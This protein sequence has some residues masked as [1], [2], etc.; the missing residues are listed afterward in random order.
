MLWNEIT[1][2]MLQ[3]IPSMVVGDFNCVESPLDKKGGKVFLKKIGS[4]FVNSFLSMG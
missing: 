1:S 2:I 4:N 3:G